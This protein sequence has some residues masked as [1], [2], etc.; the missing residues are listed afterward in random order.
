MGVADSGD[1]SDLGTVDTPKGI[2]LEELKADTSLCHSNRNHHELK[3]C[4]NDFNSGAPTKIN[5][6]L[7]R[8][9]ICNEDINED[10]IADDYEN[11]V[12]QPKQYHHEHEEEEEHVDEHSYDHDHKHDSDDDSDLLK[13]N[14][15]GYGMQGGY[16]GQQDEVNC[17]DYNNCCYGDGNNCG[18]IDCND[19]KYRSCM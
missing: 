19:Q 6:C 13:E 18:N 4:C 5:D 17:D 12:C 1:D 2:D 14:F 10:Q 15:D 16:G 11:H 9:K 8:L 3:E 7:E